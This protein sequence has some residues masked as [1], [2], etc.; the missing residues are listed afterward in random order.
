MMAQP[1]NSPP[2][3][4]GIPYGCCTHVGDQKKP[5]APSFGLAQFGPRFPRKQSSGQDLFIL[6]YNPRGERKKTGEAGQ[7]G[8]QTQGLHFMPW[9]TQTLLDH[10][11]GF[12]TR[13]TVLQNNACGRDAGQGDRQTGSSFCGLL[14]SSASTGVGQ[15]SSLAYRNPLWTDYTLT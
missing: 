10:I 7:K 14:A 3:R 11:E 8:K 9:D 1:V 4:T 2:A 13:C 5:L 6:Y 12:R 15:R